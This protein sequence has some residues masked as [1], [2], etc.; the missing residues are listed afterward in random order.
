MTGKA[1]SIGELIRTARRKHGWS[2]PYLGRQL[3]I[4]E[5]RGGPGPKRD[6]V[7][8]WESG[9]RVPVYWL[10]YLV[11]VLGLDLDAEPDSTSHGLSEGLLSDTVASVI[12]LGRRDVVDRRGFV[13]ASSAYALAALG[14]PDP[15]GVTRRVR[16]RS[17]GAVRVGRGEVAAV[18]QMTRSLGDAAAELGGGHAR[19]LAVRYLND[20]VAAWLDGTWS[21]DTGRELFAATAQLV[22]LAGWM[23]QD[24]GQQGLAQRYYAHS[25][26]LA[27]EA[28]EPELSATALRGLAVQAM[29]LGYRATAVRLA[30]ECVHLSGRVDD[31]RAVA[32][33][34]ATLAQAA[35]LDGDR[36][37]ASLALRAS[38]TAI[39]RP[40]DGGSGDSW[41]SHYDPGRWAH[42]SGMVLARLGDFSGAHEHLNHALDVHGLDRRRTRAIVLADLGAVQFRQ[43]DLDG[44]LTSWHAFLDCADGVHSVKVRTAVDDM[45]ARLSRRRS[46]PAIAALDERAAA[47]KGV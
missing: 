37:A 18:R 5:G 3:G 34:Q 36:A 24:E 30:E 19:H 42:E 46:A 35:A 39:E 17:G 26:R 13:A 40:A 27:S 20:D 7:S 4:A 6:Q 16:A 22:H 28:G 8:R 29:D 44:A 10:P 21:E 47:V 1:P 23:A 2:Q 33:Y 12:E 32:Y 31:P 11:Q 43:D 9:G 25:Y 15:D 14:L 41:A 38:Q 45:R